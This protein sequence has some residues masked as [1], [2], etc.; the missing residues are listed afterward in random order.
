MVV[1]D[2]CKGDV[3]MPKFVCPFCISEY[4]SN[5]IRYFCPDE[6]CG[7]E[8]TPGFFTK[9]FNRSKRIKCSNPHHP[10]GFAT[11]RVCPMSECGETIPLSALQNPSLPISIVGVPSSGKTNYITVMIEELHSARGLHFNIGFQN[12][13]T[14]LHQ[15]ENR[16]KIYEKRTPPDS[17][18]YLFPLPQIW[19]IRN[20]NIGPRNFTIFDGAG[21]GV[22]ISKDSSVGR[23][24]SKS[25]AILLVVDPLTLSKVRGNGILDEE[26][27][28]NSLAGNMGEV[29]QANTV[30]TRINT[31]IRELQHITGN[32]KLKIPVAVVFTK[33]DTILNKYPEFSQ[34]ALIRQPRLTVTNGVISM[35]EIEQVNAEIEN[36][37]YA[38]GEDGFLSALANNFEE[39]KLFGV[40]SY[41][42]PP[43]SPNELPEIR[44]HRVLDPM[45]WLFKRMKYID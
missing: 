2:G 40:S 44:P 3:Y 17:T 25:K 36:W 23:Y 31:E 34:D 39:Y 7:A 14:M 32:A 8:A 20:R 1:T 43:L 5:K 18:R 9:L 45:L 28:K 10:N 24:I 26:V 27:I 16:D 30:L 38:I 15:K 13:E 42:S 37:L 4:N 29:W 21:E 22:T 35:E 6:Y 12:N 19:E 11:K 33:F 41:G